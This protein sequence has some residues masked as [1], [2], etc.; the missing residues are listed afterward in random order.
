MNAFTP[1]PT[2]KSGLRIKCSK[3][4]KNDASPL[5]MNDKDAVYNAFKEILM[6]FALLT[7]VGALVAGR[8]LAAAVILGIAALLY[9][10]KPLSRWRQKFLGW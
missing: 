5:N 6:L 3:L 7:G 9:F 8:Y 2:G 10:E 1:N 4:E